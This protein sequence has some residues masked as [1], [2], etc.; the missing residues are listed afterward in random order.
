M[1]DGFP[2]RYSE[3]ED[4]ERKFK[5]CISQSAVRTKFEQHSQRGKLIVSEIQ[6][7]M[8]NAYD[9]AQQLKE[10]KAGAKKEI[11]DKL[12]STE[13]QLLLLTQKMEDK[14]RQMVKYVEQNV[15]Y[16]RGNSVTCTGGRQ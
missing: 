13:Q 3:F 7:I 2:D 4:F 9:Q 12:K 10:Q 16:F 8:E 6:Q 1:A 5:E 15:G 14:I 11:Y